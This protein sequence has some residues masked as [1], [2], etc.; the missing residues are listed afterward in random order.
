MG[1][2]DDRKKEREMRRIHEPWSVRMVHGAAKIFSSFEFE[3][4]ALLTTLFVY[5]GIR[6]LTAPERYGHLFKPRV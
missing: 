3:V 6:E 2:L 4:L 5:Y 1:R